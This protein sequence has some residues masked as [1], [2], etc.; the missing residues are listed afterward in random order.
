MKSRIICGVLMLLSI[1]LNAQYTVEDADGVLI[2]DGSTRTF[3][4]IDET[5]ATLE[6]YVNNVTT[7]PINVKIEF[8]SAVNADGSEIE[9]CFG[10]CYTSIVIGNAYP[11]GT[12]NYVTIDG[13]GQTLAGNHFYNSSDGGGA[14]IDYVFRYYMVDA[15]GNDI[16]NS[17]TFT[18]RY[19][20]ALGMEDQLTLDVD[21]ASTVAYEML[22]VSAAEQMVAIIYDIQG[23]LVLTETIEAGIQQLD[24]SALPS[25]MY[26]VQFS[27]D[28]GLKKTTKFLKR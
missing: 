26:I 14:P 19:D 13:G 5:I 17:T 6:F 20:P 4:T 8:V 15:A 22:S 16:G 10:L 24:V 3:G 28:L 1:S 23:K 12:T 2:E 25:Q 18:Y 27:N 11:L 7:D 9:L 21:V